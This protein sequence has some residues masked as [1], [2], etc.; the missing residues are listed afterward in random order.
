[1][2][3][4]ILT[5]TAVAVAATAFAQGFVNF[6]PGTFSVTTNTSVSPFVGGTGTGGTSGVTATTANGFYY[7]LLYVPQVSPGV[8]SYTGSLPTDTNAFDATG[9]NWQF[10]GI[11]S[12]N[13]STAGRVLG[14]GTG[15]NV[16]GLVGWGNGETNYFM[17]V[18][19]SANLGDNWTTVSNELAN[20]ALLQSI[21]G[22]IYF[23]NTAIGFENPSA[24]AP[25]ISLF[26]S[27]ANAGGQPIVIANGMPLYLIP[28]PEPTTV[29][30]AGLG[31]L[32]ML[33][34]RRRK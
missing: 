18:G 27:T 13:S 11:I 24:A 23:G 33:L 9:L 32:S 8:G 12:T 3:K 15:V 17:L 21:S 2:K 34:F 20:P 28:V 26:G 30:L 19:W 10:G 5:M 31:G 25:G 29:A 22:P 7:A 1:M 4:I 6:S 16:D 14:Q